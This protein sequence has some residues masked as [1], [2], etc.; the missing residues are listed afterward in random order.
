MIS[1]FAH[2]NN[3]HTLGNLFSV[4]PLRKILRPVLYQDA[5]RTLTVPV[6]PAIFM[7]MDL[8]DARQREVAASMAGAIR[9]ASP[10]APILNH[11]AIAC[12]RYELL[13]RTH[14]LG[15]SPV[16]A[17]RLESG[18]M[19]QRYPVFIRSE[20]GA[21]G[22]ETG[23]LHNEADYTQAVEDLRRHGKPAKGRIAVSYHAQPGADGYFRKFGAFRIGDS[24]IPQHIQFNRD[25]VVKANAPDRTETHIA[26]EQAYC[27]LNPHPALVMP[28]FEAGH[29][30]FGRIDYGFV[31][32]QFCLYEINTNPTFPRFAGGDQKRNARRLII[33]NA[34]VEALQRIDDGKSSRRSVPFMPLSP[35][36]DYVDT[37]N[38]SVLSR[39][40]WRMRLVLRKRAARLK[41][42]SES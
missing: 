34:V 37:H 2:A 7:D 30:E 4:A 14:R 32:G 3:T 39:S 25:W 13:S 21:N 5:F 8:L 19:P 28:V 22:P 6:G 15:L 38:W 1:V 29:I 9:A 23:L 36:R 20:C 16:Q 10:G 17:T 35:Y 12:E 24:I 27:E 33:R 18:D 26:E 42:G 11:P 41:P 31:D 40:A